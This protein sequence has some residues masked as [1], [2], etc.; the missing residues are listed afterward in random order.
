MD[1]SIA[2]TRARWGR[3]ALSP[4][5]VSDRRVRRRVAMAWGL[6][7]LNA[8]TF[9]PG[10]PMLIPIPHRFGQ[11]ITQGALP[12]AVLVALTVN[13]KI[14]V[15]PN[16]FLCLTSL[17]VVEALV[18]FLEPQ[19]LG[20]VYR[21]FR[22]AEFIAALWLLS[23]WWGRRDLLLLRCHLMALSVILGSALAGLLIHP[24]AAMSQGRLTDVI[25][26]IPTTEVGHYAAVSVGAV[27]VLWL[28]GRLRGLVTIGAV[29]G[30]GTV[31]V[32]THTRTALVALVA[33]IL[34]A[35]LSLF[36]ARG[37]VRRFFAAAGVA[38]SI[39]VM[40]AA[41]V[42]TT[43]LARGQNSQEL[44]SLSG[45]TE[46]WAAVLR[47][48][49]NKFQEIFGFGLSSGSVGGLPIDS[50]WLTAYMQEGLVGVIL[51]A[52]MLL[53]VILMAFFQPPGIRRALSL[54]LSTYVLVA[55][56]TQVGFADASTYLLEITLAASLLVPA[57]VSVQGRGYSD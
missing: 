12:A 43:W 13:R 54:F 23:P 16:V 34:V 20:A 31:L 9:Y 22:L 49:R 19:P 33:G 25:W 37:R 36:T 14:M 8:L 3:P 28:G 11:V 45:R 51:C 42:I 21:T 35:G 32:L 30:A 5:A 40:T 56:F 29:A 27:V 57:D 26:P 10:W 48:P 18:T 55:S 4:T 50:N 24:G 44:T 17:L 1:V 39:G 7:V 47:V 38:G 52:M 46:F 2:A 53:F 15:R 41:G 6:L